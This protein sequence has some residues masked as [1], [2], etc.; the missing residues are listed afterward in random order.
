MV[1]VYAITEDGPSLETYRS[2]WP[3]RTFFHGQIGRVF[4]RFG[5]HPYRPMPLIRHARFFPA[6]IMPTGFLMVSDV[7]AEAL[8]K[9]PG[10]DLNPCVL[11]Q[12][13]D[14]PFDEK[15]IH[16]L[17]E[18]FSFFGS[19]FDEWLEPR[20]REPAESE[21]AMRYVELIAPNLTRMS[22]RYRYGVEIDLPHIMPG[23]RPIRTCEAIHS[24]F[25]LSRDGGYYFASESVYHVLAP[26]LSDPEMFNVTTVDIV[27]P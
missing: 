2:T 3:Y 12:V 10:L 19:G 23:S 6:A 27:D 20:L 9:M 4:N 14:L 1:R 5:E 24:D 26:H 22:G 15:S 8:R 18:Q 11:H 21:R 7:L 16:A 13:Y 25:A 17:I